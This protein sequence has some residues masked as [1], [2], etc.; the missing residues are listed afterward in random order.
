MQANPV[1]QPVPQIAEPIADPSPAAAAA[2]DA[3]PT[4]RA[5]PQAPARAITTP[6]APET[7][8][9]APATAEPEAAPL[10]LAV[11]ASPAPPLADATSPVQPEEGPSPALGL[12][13]LSALFGAGA[14]A[15]RRRRINAQNPP[16]DF[17][18]PVV[19][20]SQREPVSGNPAAANLLAGSATLDRRS[21]GVAEATLVDMP[22]RSA[23]MI[24]PGPLPRGEELTALFDR[25]VMAA[26][27]ADNP[28]TT[29][30]RRRKQVRILMRKHDNA[31]RV[32]DA[33]PF[34]FRTYRSG[35]T[36]ETEDAG[37]TVIPA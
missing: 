3:A 34:D 12:L 20:G 25:M 26:P 6:A 19:V 5:A 37:R 31:A 32:A 10:P 9:S 4:T 16:L 11:A 1:V 24:P 33:E 22:A 13:A 21:T 7:V 17:Q 18:R 8:A 2:A 15:L 29:G 14:L 36:L 35:R 23:A 30:K 28:F 27:D